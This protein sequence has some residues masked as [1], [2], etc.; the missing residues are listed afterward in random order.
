MLPFMAVIMR[1]MGLPGAAIGTVL[2]A[3]QIVLF[4]V[5]PL[6]GVLMDKLPH[7]KAVVLRCGKGEGG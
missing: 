3:K 6:I 4:V 1:Q 7:K 2:A 5:R